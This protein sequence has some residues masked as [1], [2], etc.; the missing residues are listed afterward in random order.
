MEIKVGQKWDRINEGWG[1]EVLKVDENHIEMKI[2]G[3]P[4]YGKTCSFDRKVVEYSFFEADLF[5]L[6][7][8]GIVT[9]L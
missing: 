4:R 5:K 9:Y 3:E 8:G 2:Y 6:K 7:Q 1:W